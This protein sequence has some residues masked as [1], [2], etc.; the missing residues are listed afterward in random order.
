MI[1]KPNDY[2]L[3][4]LGSRGTRPTHGKDFEIFGGQTTCF[5][6][7][8][9]KHA[10]IVD[11]GTGLYDAKKLLE[12]CEIIDIVFT[13]VHYDHLLGL[14]DLSI[15]PKTA[16]VNFLGTFKSWLSYDT[17]DEFYKHP[18]W[19]IKPNIGAVCEIKNDGS[20][21]NM[22]DDIVLQTFSS[23]H[24][25]NGNLIMFTIKDKK[26]CFMFD[27]EVI[28]ELDIDFIANCDFLIFD[29]MYDDSE[30]RNH[31]GWGHSTYQEGC[32]LAN[33]YNCKE[34]LITHHNPVNDDSKLL[35]Y[36][37]NAKK[38]FAKTRFLRA[39]DIFAIK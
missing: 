23:N 21:Y 36:E 7:K 37:S 38:I 28:P 19:P 39:G 18:F 10:I 31:L 27:V 6:I 11:C 26:I 34:L 33:M 1:Q 17:I 20:K 9:K 35:K 4:T 30:Y 2:I 24:P 15:F 22:C 29:G 5:L 32:R 14:L 12:D 25:D 3:Y 13:H 16:R 8:H